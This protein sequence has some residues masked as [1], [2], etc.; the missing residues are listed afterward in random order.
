MI[1]GWARSLAFICVLSAA[2]CGGAE[3]N[4]DFALS[5]IEDIT[6]EQ[7]QR[8][9]SARIFFGHQSVGGNVLEGVQEVLA[10]R[11][12]IPLKVI[13]IRSAGEIGAP[14]LYH[15]AVGENGKPA[16]KLAAFRTIVGESVDEGIALLKYCYVDIEADTDPAVLFAE[17]QQTVETLKAQR[18]D[19]K[20]VHVTLPLVTDI[21][22]LRYVAAR[23]RGLP[24]GRERNL[25][26]HQYN[27]LLRKAYAGREPIF[28]LARLEST[29]AAGE[30]VTVRFQGEAIPVLASEWTYDGGHL[31]EA[32]RR[33]MAEAFLVTLAN[34]HGRATSAP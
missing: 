2:A 10:R 5:T 14:G 26:R 34:A 15:A 27:E 33:R 8:L 4:E 29:N 20:V 17:Y 19:V 6:S 30:K 24:T 28:D 1:R 31:N 11:T 13:E 12:D 18:P 21:G 7:W 32:G 3:Q 16:T 25:I 9:A 23:A 22:T